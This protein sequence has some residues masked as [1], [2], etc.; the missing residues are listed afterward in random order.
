VRK[1]VHNETLAC[2]VSSSLAER[3]RQRAANEGASPSEYIRQLIR[4]EVLEVA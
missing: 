2:R 4:R 1:P 3:V